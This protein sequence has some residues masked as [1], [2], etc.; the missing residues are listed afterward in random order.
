MLSFTRSLFV[1]LG[2]LTHMGSFWGN[3][4]DRNGC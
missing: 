2:S 4:Y 1:V 3:G